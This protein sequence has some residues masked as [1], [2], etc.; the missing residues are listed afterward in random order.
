MKVRPLRAVETGT[1][2]LA[3]AVL[4]CM[5][6]RAQE[7]VPTTA[8]DGRSVSAIEYSPQPPTVYREAPGWARPLLRFV[9]TSRRTDSTAV[10]PF[11]LLEP[12]E[13]CT[14]FL[15]AE[16]ERLLRAQTYLADARV[17]ALPEPDGGLR[18]LVETSDDVPVI[19]GGSFSGTEPRR[20]LFGNGNVLGKGMLLAGEWERGGAYREGF[21]IHFEHY[22]A[23]GGRQQ[24]GVRAMRGPIDEILEFSLARRYLTNAQ[25]LAWHAG[26]A[27]NE[28]YLPFPRVGRDAISLVQSREMYG[29]SALVRVGGSS[30]RA[31]AGISLG[32]ER[33]EQIGEGLI[34]SDSGFVLEPGSLPAGTFADYKATRLAAVVGGRWLEFSRLLILDSLG[35]RQDVPSGMM[36]LTTAGY[37]FGEERSPRLGEPDVSVRQPFVMADAYVGAGWDHGFMSLNIDVEGRR[38]PEGGWRDVVA[39]GQ[40]AW[41]RRASRRRTHAITFS[42]SATWNS[43]RPY[44]LTLANWES[45]VRG[46]S[47]SHVAGGRLAL[48]RLEERWSAGGFGDLVGFGGALFS[49]VGKMWAGD[50]PFGRST[51]LRASVGAGL[52]VAV[53]RNSQAL[54][55]LDVAAPLMRD[56][57]AGQ[58]ALRIS[59]QLP[60]STI[61]R[62]SR[63]LTRARALRTERALIATP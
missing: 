17:T 7:V 16:S 18:L 55:R 5:S 13:E 52:L 1:C 54:Y 38:D 2:L 24:L 35:G 11:L 43:H 33:L 21:G 62:E 10:E 59:R 32:H 34:V 44:R 9:L 42:Y 46:Y 61:W 50:V 49:D 12:G 31:L 26:I 30:R 28:E 22:H 53:P 56:R 57:D 15:R 6:L 14:E 45:G 29:A 60:Y 23:L 39:G 27:R 51:S 8:C 36:L 37:E 19:V 40:A 48:L 3:L 41:Y 63:D 58:W 4:P 47:G 25:R 20:L